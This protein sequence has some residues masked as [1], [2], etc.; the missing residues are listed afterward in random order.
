MDQLEAPQSAIVSE[1]TNNIKKN[2][3]S[4]PLSSITETSTKARPS[5]SNKLKGWT[6]HYVTMK[7]W[8]IN[9]N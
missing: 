8:S 1:V 2:E 4:L 6:P 9:D 3:E 7:S 5:D